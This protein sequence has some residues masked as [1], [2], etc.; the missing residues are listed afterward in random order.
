[1]S[2]SVSQ[3]DKKLESVNI[4]GANIKFDYEKDSQGLP[5]WDKIDDLSTQIFTPQDKVI[6]KIFNTEV[7]ITKKKGYENYMNYNISDPDKWRS[8]IQ[9][10]L[11]KYDYQKPMKPSDLF[12]ISKD[13]VRKQ[14][15]NDG[16]DVNPSGMPIDQIIMDYGGG[17]CVEASCALE[18]I[19]EEIKKIV[20]SPYLNNIKFEE[21]FVYPDGAYGMD[22]THAMNV[23]LMVSQENNQEVIRVKFIDLTMPYFSKTQTS[24]ILA[25]INAQTDIMTGDDLKDTVSFLQNH[26]PKGSVESKL[27]NQVFSETDFKDNPFI[28][29]ESQKD[30]IVYRDSAQKNNLK[31]AGGPSVE[32]KVMPKQ[33]NDKLNDLEKDFGKY[34]VSQISDEIDKLVEQIKKADKNLDWKKNQA[35][36]ILRLKKKISS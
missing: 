14:L 9:L 11:A 34:N 13:I 19:S 12:K 21:L 27:A 7:G 24:S 33:I 18:V 8:F 22:I 32:V 29:Q 28:V 15:T 1:V 17:N 26:F 20:G 35:R 3:Q 30:E 31:I 6:K 2:F 36:R 10:K 23:A 16:F 4:N 5:G 25:T